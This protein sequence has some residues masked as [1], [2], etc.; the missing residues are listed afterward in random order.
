MFY[1]HVSANNVSLGISGL[2]IP[3]KD[4]ITKNIQVSHISYTK[5]DQRKKQGK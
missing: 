4:T 5:S 3:S 2:F 1:L